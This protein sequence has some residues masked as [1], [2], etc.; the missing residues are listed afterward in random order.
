M[1]ICI[2]KADSLRC[3]SE[4]NTTLQINYTPKIFLKLKQYG[5]IITLIIDNLNA[6]IK[7]QIVRSIKYQDATV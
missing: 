7:E 1:D 5:K 3:T 6:S 2:C 4:T